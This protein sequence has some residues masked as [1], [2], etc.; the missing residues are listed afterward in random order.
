M[1]KELDPNS[2]RPLA[3][4]YLEWMLQTHHSERT[5]EVRRRH[6]KYFFD[7]CGIRGLERPDEINRSVME[8]Y[9]RYLYKY[10]KKNGE[11]L[12]ISSQI[13]RLTAPRSYFKYLSQR[14]LIEYNPAADLQMPRQ[15][16]RLPQQILSQSEVARV[17]NQPDLSTD[18]GIRDRTILELFYST[19][20][21]RMELVNLSIYD[22]DAVRGIVFIKN[23]KGRKDRVIPI[24]ERAL[25]WLDK[26]QE[27]V[28]D[29]LLYDINETKLFLNIHGHG[30]SEAYVTELCGGYIKKAG[31]EKKGSCHIFRHTVATLMLENG[32]DIRYIQQMLGHADI[33]TTQIYTQVSI[34]QLQSVYKL[35]HPASL[36]K[37]EKP[38]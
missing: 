38:Q 4:R 15:D 3:E 36:S 33:K 14:H 19:G 35:T 30:I 21:R 28:R 17:M 12:V 25:N 7:W 10:R 8:A 27:Q 20:M 6:L 11:P 22:V 34:K 2:F 13:K 5:V 37:T 18:E 26:Y 16:V 32:A 9:Q 29:K 1:S 31:V 23:G 24:G